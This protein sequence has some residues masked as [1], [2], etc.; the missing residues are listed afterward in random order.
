MRVGWPPGFLSP[1]R[2][3][4]PTREGWWCLFVAIGLGFTAI[5]SGNNLLY[6]LESLLL[7][8]IIVSGVLSEQT[9]RGVGV[10][11]LAPDELFAGR[12]A[13]VGAALVNAK[14]LPARSLAIETTDGE[15]VIPVR[16]LAPGGERVLAWEHTFPRR[17]RHRLPGLR[18]TTRFPFGLFVKSG[19]AQDARDVVVYPAP[20]TLAAEPVPA[21]AT[22]DAPDSRRRRGRSQELHDL[23]PYRDGDDPRLIH[24]R[25]SARTGVTTVREFEAA[26][27]A[28]VRIVLRGTGARSSERLDRAL[29]EAAAL[30]LHFTGRGA[31]ISLAGP[32]LAVPPGRG[33]EH[34]RRILEAL[35]LYEPA[36]LRRAVAVEAARSRDLV[37][38]LD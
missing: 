18:V 22:G 29:G 1:R 34:A 8:L 20:A 37:V 3:I 31:A 28:D 35:A 33:R 38:D 5:N 2:T 27:T 15:R 36:P 12:P 7:A 30:T 25:V 24:W 10:T 14:R 23:R 26:A 6:L 32:G 11:T 9:I 16:W 21:A 19:R 13:T 4:H 17:G